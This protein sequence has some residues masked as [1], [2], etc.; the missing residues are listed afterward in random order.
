MLSPRQSKAA[1]RV[2]EDEYVL[3]DLKSAQKVVIPNEGWHPFFSPDDQCLDVYKRQSL[4]IFSSVV[5]KGMCGRMSRIVD[6]PYFTHSAYSAFTLSLIHIW[7]TKILSWKMKHHP[8][9]GR[10][11]PPF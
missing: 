3:V 4:C 7:K 9:T 1:Y 6:E 8:S 10:R 5:E 2:T 11:L